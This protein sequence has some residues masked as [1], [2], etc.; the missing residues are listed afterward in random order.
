[1]E[2]IDP[3]TPGE[4]GATAE[5]EAEKRRRLWRE[6]KRRQR[7]EEKEI[8]VAQTTEAESEWWARNRDL[9]SPT[10]LE[11]MQAQ[12]R[13]CLDFITMMEYATRNN[14]SLDD[15][16]YIFEKDCVAGLVEFVKEF[17]V[18]HLGAIHRSSEIPP[19]WSGRQYWK[20]PQLLAALEQEGL[21]TAQLV[22]YGLL[23][24]L[25]DF[26]VERFLV[27]KAKWPWMRV[28]D[29]LGYQIDHNNTVRYR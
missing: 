9:L 23:A 12:D 17:G 4:A 26:R 11:A 5:S 20:E 21:Q 2:E 3:I 18:T 24:A 27:D 1:M 25:P 13:L 22:R 16:N 10:E 29:L 14:I 15:L 8:K 7:A 6:R 28:A 19:D